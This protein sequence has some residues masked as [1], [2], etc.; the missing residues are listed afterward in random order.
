MAPTPSSSSVLSKSRK[1]SVTPSRI[2]YGDYPQAYT[3][4]TS[5]ELD[6]MPSHSP[7][8]DFMVNPFQKLNPSCK[9]LP[10][11]PHH[12][13]RPGP[14]SPSAA[15]HIFRQD[16]VDESASDNETD[17]SPSPLLPPPIASTSPPPSMKM[18]YYQ[19]KPSHNAMSYSK[20]RSDSDTGNDSST[21]KS[22]SKSSPPPPVRWDRPDPQTKV[23]ELK[24]TQR[25]RSPGPVTLVA[26]AHVQGVN[27]APSEIRTLPHMPLSQSSTDPSP[28]ISLSLS[29]DT[30]SVEAI[31]SASENLSKRAT[32]QHGD[33]ENLVDTHYL[34]SA[35]TKRASSNHQSSSIRNKIERT[36][37]TLGDQHHSSADPLMETSNPG[38]YDSVI[39]DES[40]IQAEG[41]HMWETVGDFG[42]QS[43]SRSNSMHK[44]M[45]SGSSVADM[46]SEA[47]SSLSINRPRVTS[48]KF[49]PQVPWDPITAAYPARSLTD[50]SV[51]IL[52]APTIIKPSQRSS[53]YGQYRHP[54][55]LPV[56]HVHPLSS[57]Q[58][59]RHSSVSDPFTDPED[60]TS[61]GGSNREHHDTTSSRSKDI[62]SSL[63]LVLSDARKFSNGSAANFSRRFPVIPQRTRRDQAKLTLQQHSDEHTNPFGSPESATVRSK[64]PFA[65]GQTRSSSHATS[66]YA[67]QLQAAHRSS[68]DGDGSVTIDLG[69]DNSLVSTITCPAF[70]AYSSSGSY[71]MRIS[72][73]NGNN[74]VPM[75][76]IVPF[77]SAYCHVHHRREFPY[78]P[79]LNGHL[80]QQRGGQHRLPHD[81]ENPFDT[82][83]Y[84]QVNIEMQAHQ[85]RAGKNLIILFTT[86]PI[87][88]WA[89]LPLIASNHVVAGQVMRLVTGGQVREGFHWRERRMARRFGWV[90]FGVLF[91]AIVVLVV[92]TIIGTMHD[93]REWTYDYDEFATEGW[94]GR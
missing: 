40:S 77:Q 59:S 72:S 68:T 64:V 11:V 31:R 24:D 67:M 12:M 28:Q 91:A 20:S 50:S 93:S 37:D 17:R 66:W 41:E 38:I 22:R 58:V 48:R 55:P 1:R 16:N 73:N 47:T 51:P 43:E 61:Q 26:I 44:K 83:F 57:E 74:H 76:Y 45:E 85:R 86:F 65:P 90:L 2:T 63:S 29:H 27:D 53:S 94:G 78:P 18:V 88:G 36:S 30:N 34:P 54:S 21:S 81:P 56:N 42:V 7:G 52:P 71:A 23:A 69:R 6:K 4:I 14:L 75:Q 10:Q 39:P 62:R 19:Q 33:V 70:N 9:N 35:N 5:K 92:I 80:Q 49:T 84:G 25:G 15:D 87:L 46:S 79:T 32:T 13:I 3:R 60:E 89:F 82:H 8:Q